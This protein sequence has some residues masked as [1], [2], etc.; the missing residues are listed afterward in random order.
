[1]ETW[2]NFWAPLYRDASHE[3]LGMNWE[4]TGERLLDTQRS[5]K[6]W[7][8]TAPLMIWLTFVWTQVS[9]TECSESTRLIF[10]IDLCWDAGFIWPSTSTTLR[11]ADNLTSKIEVQLHIWGRPY[12]LRAESR[13]QGPWWPKKKTAGDQGPWLPEKRQIRGPDD[14]KKT[15]QASG[16]EMCLPNHRSS[17]SLRHSF[18]ARLAHHRVLAHSLLNCTRSYTCNNKYIQY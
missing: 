13:D 9:L 5:G 4:N 14:Q 3:K 12:V 6:V 1:M 16:T 17:W 15:D 8:Y 2:G 18:A 11:N 7:E 10:M